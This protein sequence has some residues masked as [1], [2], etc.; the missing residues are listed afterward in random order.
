VNGRLSLALVV[1]FQAALLGYG[2][3]VSSC[4]YNEE[5]HIASGLV[6]V[7]SGSFSTF[8]VNPPLSRFVAA[9]PLAHL[10]IRTFAP[11]SAGRR[12]LPRWEYAAGRGFLE[13]NA[14]NWMHYVR[15]ARIPCTVFALVG[16]VL[17]YCWAAQ[18]YGGF[19][20]IIA[21]ALWAACPYILG[22]GCLVGP[23]VPAAAIGAAGVYYFWR[24]LKMPQWLAAMV[25]GLVLGLAELCKFT[26]LV[27][28]PLLPLLWVVYRL[29][30]RKMMNRHDWLRQ[31]GMLAAALLVSVYVINCG[32]LLEDTFTPLE[33]FR[34]QTMMFTGYDS[35]ND[36]PPEGANRFAGTWM[37]K[38]PVPLPANFVHGI[39]TQ[40][41][42]FERGLPSYL[43][44]QW[45]NHGWWYYYLYAL[46][47]KEPLGTWCLV[48]LAIGVSIFGRRGTVASGQWSVEGEKGDRHL[49]CAA[50]GGPFR[51]KVPVPLF[52][53]WRDEM[54]VL[55]P[56]LAIL[57]FVSSQTGFSVHSRYVIP[58]LP[59][60]FVWMSKVGRALERREEKTSGQ[61]PV[62][63]GQM[64]S[65]PHPRPLSIWE[66]GVVGWFRSRKQPV[67]AVLVILALTWSVGSS[68][69]VYPH[70]LSYFNELAAVLPTPADVSYPKPPA[71]EMK[72]RGILA[73]LASWP[74][75]GPRNGPRHLLD[76]N[77]DWGQDLFYLKDWLDKH[78]D[79]KLD[80]LAVFGSYPPTLA[81]IPETPY[82]PV[83]PWELPE[84]GM[85][86]TEDHGPKPGWYALSV[87]YIYGRDRQY[88]YFLNFEPVAMAGYSIY[89]YHITPEQANHVRRELRMEEP[90][91]SG[92]AN[93]SLT[94]DG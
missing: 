62:V 57:V 45:A 21:A 78:P 54:V 24:W 47:V 82:P 35:L 20:G 87:N 44:G 86:P 3:F 8:T 90:R 12:R 73:T 31:G 23:D 53:S 89:I 70:S 36:I 88:R 5:G 63:S 85:A 51:Q 11:Y 64:D 59:F 50:P 77:I 34:F 58:A 66:R 91:S 79:V 69:A 19:A 22:H 56:G 1:L 75:A 26:P 55:V 60:F 27:F 30:E 65:S 74:S 37:G 80:G 52:P 39:D 94:A 16:S 41:Y 6:H 71:D 10:N 46:A 29:S 17:C 38:L 81:G 49:L 33:E 15:I 92:V 84:M 14:G 25:A 32:Y 48:A 40:R 18:C 83:R 7:R 13:E 72:P 28:Y 68:L 43:R 93:R 67:M 9:L 42:D 4:V 76:S 61:W 2:G